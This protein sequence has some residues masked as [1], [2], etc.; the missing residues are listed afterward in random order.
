MLCPHCGRRVNR[1]EVLQ[2]RACGECLALIADPRTPT[3]GFAD[4][5]DLP[6]WATPTNGEPSTGEQDDGWDGLAL[7]YPASPDGAVSTAEEAEE[8]DETLYEP[9]LPGQTVAGQY[10]PW[11]SEQDDEV[12]GLGARHPSRSGDPTWGEGDG[13][14][15]QCTP[16]GGR[17][18]PYGPRIDQ[19]AGEL[20]KPIPPPPESPWDDEIRVI[21]RQLAQ[22]AASLPTDEALC[23][24]CQND[25]MA[26]HS[27]QPTGLCPLC[28]TAKL[29]KRRFD[30]TL[31]PVCGDGHLSAG[32]ISQGQA[33]CPVCRSAVMQSERR[34]R[35]GLQLGVWWVCPHCRT[36]IHAVTGDRARLVR[37]TD[38]PH[39]IGA[40]YS[41]KALP[42]R[43]WRTMSGRKD[44]YFACDACAAQFEPVGGDDL[45]LCAATSDPHGVGRQRLG[46]TLPKSA[47]AKIAHRG[48]ATEGD[49]HCPQCGAEFDYDSGGALLRL[50]QMGA[51]PYCW[52]PGWVGQQRP[53]RAWYLAM[54]GKLSL[55]PGLLCPSCKTEFDA[56]ET[57]QYRLMT[58]QTA[59]LSPHCGRVQLIGDWHRIARA[60]PSLAEEE[61]LKS[62]LEDMRGLKR[63][64]DDA[65]GRA[66]RQQRE[67]IDDELLELVRMTVLE[68]HVALPTDPRLRLGIGE[69]LRLALLGWKETVRVKQGQHYLDPNGEEGTICITSRAIVFL[70]ESGYT[71]QRPLDGLVAMQEHGGYLVLSFDD[72]R[73]P[74]LFSVTDTIL[75]VTVGGT[76][77]EVVLCVSD[78]VELLNR[79]K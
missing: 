21:E 77:R 27:G 44:Q 23:P 71:W 3:R 52:D 31:C 17:A 18:D 45:T 30:T 2:G 48:S 56:E 8:E 19:L 16:S 70:G 12:D 38:D 58:T 55:R 50:L 60:L 5:P 32:V 46:Q 49:L 43:E 15:G 62:D 28:R 1:D 74:V 54:A 33:F 57:R 65:W 72:L 75:N 37:F 13:Q 10:L 11:A 22:I 69:R 6:G 41:G 26:M 29:V 51:N 42:V 73:K 25:R 66:Q 36:E 24:A 14:W 61:A 79:L 68:G 20:S 67:A 59:V 64:E 40:Q 78:A 9:D 76:T 4:D 63:E 53:V 34:R 39:G 7:A 47:W 35:F